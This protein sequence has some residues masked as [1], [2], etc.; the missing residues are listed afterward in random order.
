MSDPTPNE[1][2][3]VIDALDVL[4]GALRDPHKIIMGRADPLLNRDPSVTYAIGI[5][6]ARALDQRAHALQIPDTFQKAI[7]VWEFEVNNAVGFMLEN[8][9]LEMTIMVITTMENQY[10]RDIRSI[11]QPN[12]MKLIDTIKLF[13]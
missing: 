11:K 12:V 4:K 9:D 2:D 3:A 6:L 5:A 10:K 13:D 8:F 1:L 7:D